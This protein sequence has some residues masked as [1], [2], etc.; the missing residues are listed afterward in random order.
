M[1]LLLAK[2]HAMALEPNQQL[3]ILLTDGSS[4]SDIVRFLSQHS[5]DVELMQLDNYYS[6]NVTRG[7]P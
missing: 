7:K 1:S 5:F 3:Q 6:L 2:R 4:K